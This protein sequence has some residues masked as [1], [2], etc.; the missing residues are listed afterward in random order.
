MCVCVYVVHICADAHTTTHMH[1]W[2]L[3]LQRLSLNMQY[4]A[5]LQQLRLTS[6]VKNTHN[7]SVYAVSDISISMVTVGIGNAKLLDPS[8]D[9]VCNLLVA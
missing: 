4:Y 3:P 8:V 2:Y 7:Q 5:Y 9:A 1:Y 6:N